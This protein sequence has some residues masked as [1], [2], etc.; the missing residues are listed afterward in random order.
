M[1]ILI[2]EGTFDLCTYLEMCSKT[3]HG[4]VGYHGYQDSIRG[5]TTSCAVSMGS[6]TFS[7]QRY[8]CR[9]VNEISIYQV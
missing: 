4:R 3:G 1:Y 8:G 5:T 9:E 2:L 7:K 6:I